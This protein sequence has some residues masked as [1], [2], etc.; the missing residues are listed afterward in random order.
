M[1]KIRNL[2]KGTKQKRNMEKEKLNVTKLP[3]PSTYKPMIKAMSFA[4]NRR[5][6]PNLFPNQMMHR[7]NF[8]KN[9]P[10]CSLDCTLP[11]KLSH[12]LGLL[13]NPNFSMA[14]YVVRFLIVNFASIC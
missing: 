8:L 6:P 11:P 5:Q 10:Y 2:N 3:N 9:T 12:T 4:P 13:Q 1:R 7:I 14:P